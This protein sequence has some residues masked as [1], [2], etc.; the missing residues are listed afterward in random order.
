MI[1]RIILLFTVAAMVSVM[2]FGCGSK[3]KN[4]YFEK[5]RWGMSIDEVNESTDRL[6]VTSGDS[7]LYTDNI[8]KLDIMPQGIGIP[9][10]IVYI[11]GKNGLESVT[12]TVEPADNSSAVKLLK[13]ITKMYTEQFGKPTGDETK[14]QWK[15]GVG[16][17]TVNAYNSNIKI[18]YS[19]K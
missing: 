19:E 4:G 8:E 17:I 11:F 12:V 7:M 13:S 1:K 10:N 14:P 2:L 3:A 15:T 5:T 18:I 9:Q 6:L 16:S